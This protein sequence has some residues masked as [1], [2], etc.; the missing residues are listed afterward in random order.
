MNALS[1]WTLEVLVPDANLD[2]RA[3]LRAPATLLLGDESGAV[4]VVGLLV[5]S[6]SYETG[7][8]DGHRF[9]VELAPPAWLLTRRAGYR[10][11]LEETTQQVVVRV[12]EEAGLSNRG[13]LWR[14]AGTYMRRPQCTQYAETEWAFVERLLAEEGISYWFDWS[15][16]L[17]PIVVLGDSPKAHDGIA[18]STWITYDEG[19]GLVRPAGALIEV[20][21]VHEVSPDAVH[22]REYDIRQPDVFIEGRAGNGALEVFEFPACVLTEAA[23]EH[24]AQ[25]RLDAAPAA[26]RACHRDERQRAP[27][28]GAALSSRRGARTRG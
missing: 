24:R 15:D 26:R 12:L 18:G 16:D 21:L 1:A 28:A 20:A 2:V 22:L 23:A 4:R 8:R 7:E 6:I 10:I 17:G 13:V 27:P 11:V 25:A 14:L 5:T 3:A 19:S 9:V